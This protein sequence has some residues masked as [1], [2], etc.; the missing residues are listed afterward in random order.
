MSVN[1]QENNQEFT[2][3]FSEEDLKDIAG[4]AKPKFEYRGKPGQAPEFRGF[5]GVRP[6][7][8]FPFHK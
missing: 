4:G 1:T 5:V 3:E 8:T 2:V 6:I 7:K